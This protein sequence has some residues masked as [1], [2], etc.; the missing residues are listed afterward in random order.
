MNI[1]LHHL[2]LRVTLIVNCSLMLADQAKAQTFRT[3][4]SFTAMTPYYGGTNS[5]G[6]IPNGL[7]LSGN[8]LY[9]ASEAGGINGNGA[10]FSLTLPGRN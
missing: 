2:I 10:I 1:Y 8:T 6:D 4:Y 3:I 5:D 7:I 9:G